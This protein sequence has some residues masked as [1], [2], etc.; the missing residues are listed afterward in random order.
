MKYKFLLVIF[1]FSFSNSFS[2][3]KRAEDLIKKGNYVDALPTLLNIYK[4]S[5]DDVEVG[6]MIASCYLNTN[7]DRKAALQYIEKA[8]ELGRDLDEDVLF[9][10]ATSLTYHLR[11]REAKAFFKKYKTI[12]KGSHM[13]EV[14][15]SLQNCDAA[16]KLLK[17]PLNVTFTNLGKNVNSK[18]PDY[19]P[20]V[21]RN[22]SVLYFTSRRTGNLGGSKEFDG[23]YPADIYHFRMNYNLGKAKNAGR[24]LNSPGD[25]QVVGVS[26]S[27]H[28]LFVYFDNVEFFGDIYMAHNKAGK[29]TRN[30]RLGDAINS[31]SLET[32]AS[33]SA[34]GRTLL[35]SSDRPGGEGRQDL[36]ISR[37][38]PDES[39][40][41]AQN[42]GDV[43]NTAENEDFPQLSEDGRTLFFSSKGHP[44]MGGSDI[45][46]SEWNKENNT[47]SK[48]VNIGYPVNTP[49]DNMTISF[50]NNEQYAYVSAHRE[51]SYGYQDIYKVEFHNNTNNKTVFIFTS[52]T[53]VFD[54]S[55]EMVITDEKDAVIGLY[56]PSASGKFI[57]V[58]EKGKFNIAIEN[59][60]R[61]IYRDFLIV[62][63]YHLKQSTVN[64]SISTY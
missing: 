26:N 45:F 49:E 33:M 13:R 23:Y 21:S 27:G 20:F 38:L 44:G 39:W 4:R 35:F 60:G 48:P 7:V 34:D 58:L 37:R 11:Y 31:P 40:G 43:I 42:L 56:H 9:D 18:Y 16:M 57:V 62:S 12:G 24:A 59:E 2:Q 46:K 15:I 64:K 28:S 22:D 36:Y 5:P 61:M 29:F 1:L 52:S 10:Y 17:K 41:R 53:G 19:Y 51:D 6:L 63:D 30:F 55:M 25:D 54:D 14:D 32:S 47:W 8:Y 3:V 50:S